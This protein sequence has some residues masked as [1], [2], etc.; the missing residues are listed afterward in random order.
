MWPVK[1]VMTFGIFL[2][3]LQ[4]FATFFRDLAAARGTTIEGEPL[5]EEAS[6]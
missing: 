3:L 6:A 2:M 1:I 5:G 4:A